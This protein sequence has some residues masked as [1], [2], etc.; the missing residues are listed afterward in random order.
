MSTLDLHT[1]ACSSAHSCEHTQQATLPPFSKTLSWHPL[2][3]HPSLCLGLGPLHLPSLLLSLHQSLSS[4]SQWLQ[5]IP[6][7]SESLP[8]RKPP[9]QLF[10]GKA[11]P[12]WLVPYIVCLFPGTLLPGWPGSLS[13]LPYS[14][15]Q[16]T[17]K[18]GLLGKGPK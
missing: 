9:P 15:A 16:P 18:A 11:P 5:Q 13:A 4:L 17:C 7:A 8:L 1:C 14:P 12:G 3:S 10:L 6:L 2:Q